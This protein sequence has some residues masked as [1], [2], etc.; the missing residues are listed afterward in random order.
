M[1][2]MESMESLQRRKRLNK[3]KMQKIIGDDYN[4]IID[5]KDKTLDNITKQCTW[6]SL[7]I[8]CK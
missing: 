3:T 1:E 2:T 5:D 8:R 7:G 4:K 6:F